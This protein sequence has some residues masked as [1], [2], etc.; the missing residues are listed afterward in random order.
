MAVAA[1]EEMAL[2]IPFLPGQSAREFDGFLIRDLLAA[3]LNEFS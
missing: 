1:P 3:I 2:K